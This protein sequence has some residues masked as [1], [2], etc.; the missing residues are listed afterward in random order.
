M[1]IP[2]CLW[3]N[4]AWLF[5]KYKSFVKSGLGN[6]NVYLT[7]CYVRLDIDGLQ[8]PSHHFVF[9]CIKFRILVINSFSSHVNIIATTHGSSLRYIRS[10]AFVSCRTCCSRCHNSL[11]C[12]GAKHRKLHC[13]KSFLRHRSRWRAL[14][15]YVWLIIRL[16]LI[17]AADSI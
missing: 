14:H 17:G 2:M 16:D 15:G 7:D 1:E 12:L 5:R 4:S 10:P 13:S 3:R 8:S 6:S 11:V 9:P